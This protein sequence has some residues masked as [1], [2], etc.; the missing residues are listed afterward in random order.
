MR[1]AA[2]ALAL[3]ISTLVAPGAAAQE[4]PADTP[5]VRMRDGHGS[6]LLF[7]VHPRTLRPLSRPIRTFRSGADMALT[8]DGRRMAY[9]GGYRAGSTIHFVDFARWRSLG[10]VR[11][12]R[13][14]PL[15]VGWAGPNRVV[16]ITGQGFGRQRLL[17]VDVASKR[18]VARRAFR[19]RMLNRFAV[20][21]GFALA[22]APEGRVGPLRLLLADASGGTRTVEV[23]GIPAGGNEGERDARYLNPGIA[24]DPEGSRMLVVAARGL[25]VAEVALASGEITYHPLGAAASKG[26]VDMWWR[27]AAWVGNG[28]IAVSGEHFRPSRGRRVPDGPAPFGVRL[29]DTSDWSITTLD[30]RSSV[31]H[32]AGD[33][34]LAYGTRWFDGGRRSESTGLLAFHGDGRRAFVRFRGRDIATVGSRGHL[35]YAWV[36]RTRTLHVIDLRDGRTVNEVHTSRRIPFLL[37][38]AS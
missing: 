26:D 20:P 3:L 10:V 4:R 36:R 7:R 23:E 8:A 15:G 33:T 30:A 21:G 1:S 5:L 13:M 27:E 37:T 28:R 38:P 32:V 16:A 19:G 12:G 14:G 17:W 6:D 2:P 11:L 34:V 18:V 22:L 31:M 24:V 35:L 25:L 9:T 29:I